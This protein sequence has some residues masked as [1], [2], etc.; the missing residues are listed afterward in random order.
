MRL[1]T[2]EFLKL[3]KRL[4]LVL[5]SFAITVAPALI[6]LT[7]TEEGRGGTH[8]F[9]DQL[10]VVAP[11][12]IIAAILIGS[13]LGTADVASGVFRELVVTGRSRT[14]LYAARMPAGLA[15]VLAVGAA[16]F[17]V[18]VASA[19]VSAGPP[20]EPAFLPGGPGKPPMADLSTYAPS[21]ALVAKSGAWLAVVAV[22]AF[23]L[24]F[25]VASFVGSP[26]ASIA[27][28]LGL[29][30]VVIPLIQNIDSLDWLRKVM[31]L[32]GLDRVMPAGL[33]VGAKELSISL[34]AA[35]VV[36]LVWSVVPLAAGAYRTVTRDC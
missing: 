20:L 36:L 18:V 34:T 26:S 7:A 33:T 12:A 29:W 25:G 10:G 5:L 27:T 4:G 11:L 24:A 6:M 14:S 13:T 22:S 8:A 32:E 23:A 21:A 17:A 30:L 35:I 9:A 19:L 28:L 1:V 3:R 31:V 16:G 2:A 15:L